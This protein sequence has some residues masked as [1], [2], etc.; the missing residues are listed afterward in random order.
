MKK[1]ELILAQRRMNWDPASDPHM[2]GTD[3]YKTIFVARL[4]SCFLPFSTYL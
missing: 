4:V 2:S 3:P 1:S